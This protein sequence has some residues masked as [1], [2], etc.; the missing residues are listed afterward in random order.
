ML[1]AVKYIRAKDVM[2]LCCLK[3]YNFAQNCCKMFPVTFFGV[4]F[5]PWPAVANYQ[6]TGSQSTGIQCKY[7]VLSVLNILTYIHTCIHIH[8]YDP[9]QQIYMNT[10]NILFSEITPIRSK[11]YTI[12]NYTLL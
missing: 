12:I 6:D 5:T 4:H 8:K 1:S 2:N 3:S 10:L 9:T 11:Q 7:P